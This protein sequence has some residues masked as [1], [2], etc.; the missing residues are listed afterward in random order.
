MTFGKKTYILAN[1]DQNSGF[2]EV[3]HVVAHAFRAN[4]PK[5]DMIKLI[6]SL[7]K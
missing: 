1:E 3:K 2:V 5:V 6:F 7:L 4:M